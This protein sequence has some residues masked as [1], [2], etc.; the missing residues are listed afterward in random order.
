MDGF[1]EFFWFIVVFFALMAYL[2][3]L[4]SIITD[5]FRDR[6]TSG[7]VKALWVLFL[8]VVPFLSALI[9]LVVRSGSMAQ[10]SMAAA[11]EAKKVQDRYIRE[12]AAGKSP[13]EQIADAKALYDSG[14]ITEAE[15]H[16]L[17]AKVLM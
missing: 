15:F 9:Y 12:V 2:M 16:T 3:V 6:E 14:A 8:F 13:A 7:W 4:F 17:E 5:L 1:W 10:R 11:E